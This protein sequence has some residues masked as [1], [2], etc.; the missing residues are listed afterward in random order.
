MS[1]SPAPAHDH[2][3]EELSLPLFFATIV[4]SLAAL[5]GLFWLA[6]PH[7]VWLTQIGTTAGKFTAAFLVMHLFACFVEYFFHRY[8]LHKPVVPFLAKFYRQHTLHHNLTRIGR[9]RTSSGRE[10]PVVEN[11]FPMT[12]PEQNEAS[13]FPWFTLLVFGLI[14]TPI[15]ALMQWIMPSLPWFL[16]GYLA[17]AF[18]M[19][20][21]EVFH[22]IEHWPFEKWAVLIE[23]KRMGWFWR[24]VYSFHLRHH[25]VIDCNEAISGF[26]TLPIADF[27]F[28]TWIFP[29]SLYTDGGEWD[30]SEF[31]S[32]KPYKFIRWCDQASDEIVRNR[33]LAAQGAPQQPLLAPQ[34]T[35]SSTKM[36][37]LAHGLTHGIGLGVSIASLVLLVLFA[38]FRGDAWHVASFTVFGVT[39]VLLY[40]AFAI[41]YRRE[42]VEWKLAVRKYAHA[43]MFLVIAGTATPFLLVAMRG[44]WGWSLFGIVWGLCTAGVALQLMFSGRY[45]VATVVA[46]LLVGVLAVVAIKPVVALMT[47]GALWLVLAGVLCYTAGIAFYLWRLPKYAYVPRQLF[48]QAGSVCHLL[49]ALIFLLPQA[50]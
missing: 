1:A 46:Y 26:F 19:T 16:A 15:L 43:A 31:V 22:A 47:P 24:K 2:H 17:M 40:V 23:Q 29:K 20:L 37:R 44:P 36:E 48:F 38:V 9:K 12:Q 35:P 28:G 42:E 49:A 41:Y 34:P 32:P 8:V 33:R 6:A 14:T 21:Y 50:A 30:P 3:E 11:I 10:M 39:L 45:R 18:S 13:F 7:N 4:G 25:A 5:L 27:C